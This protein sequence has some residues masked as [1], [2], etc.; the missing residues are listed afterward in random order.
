M[1]RRTRQRDAIQRALDEAGRPLSPP[2]ILRAASRFA[3]GLG[4]ATVYRALASMV[5]EGLADVVE[6]PGGPTCYERRH[7]HHHHHFHCRTCGRVFE[8][9]GCPGHLES[10]APRGFA[11]DGHDLTLHG[12]CRDCLPRR[13]GA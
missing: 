3:P 5:G 9:E 1:E 11:V 12:T 6:L 4:Q 13:K 10:L 8:V 7:D 2:E